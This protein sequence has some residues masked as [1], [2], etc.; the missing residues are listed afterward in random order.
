VDDRGRIV[1]PALVEGQ[2]C[3]GIAQGIGGALGEHCV[4]DDNGQLLTL[5]CAT[6]SIFIRCQCQERCWLM[7]VSV[8]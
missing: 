3:G 1:N 8:P 2:S 7:D 6:I 5:A 4:Y